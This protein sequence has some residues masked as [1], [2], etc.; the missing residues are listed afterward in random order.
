MSLEG[1][2]V[3]LGV[4]GS[5]AAYKAPPL[6]RKL[7]SKGAEVIV[8]MTEA[9]TKLVDP[10]TFRSLTG[11]AVPVDMFEPSTD[12]QIEHISLSEKADLFLI[13]PATANTI[14]KMANG[15]ADNLLTCAVMAT[16]APVLIAPA[17]NVNMYE[18]P[19]VQENIK[20]LEELGYTFVGPKVG[21]LATGIEGKGPLADVDDILA[22]AEELLKGR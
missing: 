12:W 2:T 17:M 13:A 20:R 6:A 5:I 22:K 1:K 3:V 10:L 11:R 7:Q 8:V 18:N 16:K 19:I 14:G 4:T 9:G 15:I 21:R